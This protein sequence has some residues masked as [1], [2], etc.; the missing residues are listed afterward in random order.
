MIVRNEAQVIGRC[1]ENALPIV[2]GWVVADTGSTDS[3]GP[4]VTATAARWAK[5]GILLE[6]TWV[7]FGVNRTRVAQEARAWVVER[8]WSAERTYLLFLDADMVLIASPSFDKQMLDATYYQVVQDTGTIRYWNTR[9]ACLTSDWYAVG[10]THEYWEAPGAPEGGK[11]NTLVI[12]DRGDGGSKGDKLARDYRLLKQDLALDPG[13]SRHIFYLAQT[14]FDG[15]RFAEAANWYE[16]RRAAGGWEEERWYSHY[17]LGLSRLKL[18]DSQRGCGH[19]MEA[20]DERPTRAEPL[21][22]LARHH[23]EHGRSHAALLFLDRALEIPFPVDDM[24]FVE[25]SVYNWRL[26]E[27]IMISAWYVPGRRE[28]GYAAS[29]RLLLSRGHDDDFYN[30]VASNETFYHAELPRLRAGRFDVDQRLLHWDGFNYKCAN[31]T[32]VRIGSRTVVNVRLVNYEQQGGQCY[33]SAA[34]RGFHTRN[35]T[36]EWDRVSGKSHGCCES[37]GIPGHWPAAT[38]KLGLEDMRWTLHDGRVWF[39]AACYQTPD[40]V[41]HCRVV[42]GRMSEALDAVDHVM[43]LRRNDLQLA[44]K[45]WL[46]WSRAEELFVIYAYDPFEVR[47]V[48]VS[49]GETTLVHMSTPPFRAAGFRGSAPPVPI[50]NRAGRW[51][52]VTHEVAYRPHGN[53]YAHR[54]V[55]VDEE[56]GLVAASRPF[57]FDTVGIE[58]AAGLCDLGGGR[59][60]ITYGHEDREARWVELEWDTVLESLFTPPVDWSLPLA[61]VGV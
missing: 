38:Q 50:P 39:T 22:A 61:D 5:P 6:H 58:Y 16:R 29:E 4:I 17:K 54:F 52:L 32:V 27:E 7:N 2:D 30:Y 24:L 25:K 20:F 19:L 26:W 45:N 47:R 10:S 3:T 33:V 59:L 11:L 49:T 28:Q 18:G 41:D 53:A 55:E 12:D 46:P 15:G 56:D 8:G 23:R 34:D 14:C 60:L 21:W 31:P 36:L 42:L 44:E 57:H 43:P 40:A 9:L 48:D 1:L 37:R 35:V 51:V 13:N